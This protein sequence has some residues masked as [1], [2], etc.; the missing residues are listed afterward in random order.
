[1]PKSLHADTKENEQGELTRQPERSD[2]ALPEFHALEAL[3]PI[4]PLRGVLSPERGVLFVELRV[5]RIGTTLL[6]RV[7]S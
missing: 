4:L 6:I 2:Q 7:K 3:P 1:M 5:K